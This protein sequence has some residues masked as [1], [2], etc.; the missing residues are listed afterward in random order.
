MAQK[1]T[2]PTPRP[3]VIRGTWTRLLTFVWRAAKLR[4]PEC[5][6]SP[7]FRPLR[8]ARSPHDWLN[9]L[10][11]C[12]ICGYA[13]ER[14]PGYFLPA[15]WMVQAFS[16]LGLGIGWGLFAQ[17]MWSPPLPALF[18]IACVP[19]LLFAFLFARHSKAIYLAIEHAI[20]PHRR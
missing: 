17:W 15:T 1:V 13:Y 2:A 19:A 3:P 12:A 14:E 20:D 8:L 4:C 10:P 9:P 16:V 18:A 7:V 11:G 5:G 6:V